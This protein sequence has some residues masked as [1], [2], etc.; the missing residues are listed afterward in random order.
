MKHKIESIVV[1][2]VMAML[3]I[4]VYHSFC[5]YT[6]EWS[7]GGIYVPIWDKVASFFD[8]VDLPM[9]IFISGYL[10][11]YLF[12]NKGKYRDRRSFI[13][14]K[15]KRLIVP[16]IFWGLFLIFFMPELHKWRSLLTGISHLW[17]L[18]VLFEIFILVIPVVSWLCEKATTRLFFLFLLCLYFL[19]IV[20]HRYSSHHAF[21]AFHTTMYYLPTFIIGIACARY[22]ISQKLS[23]VW[24]VTIFVV[25]FLS[26]FY[27]IF[28]TGKLQYV[29]NYL[30]LQLI[31]TGFVI[32]LFC[33]L[34]NIRFQLGLYNSFLH[35]DR[36]SMGI[37]IFNQ[38]SINAFLLINGIVPFLNDNYRE[39]PI[40]ICIVGFLAPLLLSYLFNRTKYIKWTIG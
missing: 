20:F 1:M 2:R 36:L 40:I 12:I 17:F 24:S 22:K 38:I 10:F 23:I 35:L 7:M 18:L 25:S 26:L 9:F 32:S 14:S 28:I 31:G 11:G 15:A 8:A 27:Y 33:I 16:Y 13:L 39:G 37:Y 4:I 3:M 34:N 19:F 29:Q 21:L 5:F 30:L 6:H